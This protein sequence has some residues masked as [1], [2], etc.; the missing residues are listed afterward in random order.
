MVSPHCY[1]QERYEELTGWKCPRQ[2]GKT[3]ADM[4]P[5]ERLKDFDARMAVSAELGHGRE[6]VTR[7]YLGR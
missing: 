2:G 5:E 1:A 3:F 6:Y 4:T 7:T